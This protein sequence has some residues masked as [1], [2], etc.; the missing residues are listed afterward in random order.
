MVIPR[1][2]IRALGKAGD[3]WHYRCG[4]TGVKAPI[5]GTLIASVQNDMNEGVVQRSR[6]NRRFE[7]QN[8]LD[9]HVLWR[10]HHFWQ[11]RLR[12]NSDSDHTLTYHWLLCLFASCHGRM[13]HNSRTIAGEVRVN[14]IPTIHVFPLIM[15]GEVRYPWTT[16][17]MMMS[18]DIRRTLK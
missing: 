15:E 4:H 2:L 7:R 16:G 1:K 11:M 3:L 5:R 8:R 12:L 6:R 13:H 17:P 10:V 14:K 9:K 18:V